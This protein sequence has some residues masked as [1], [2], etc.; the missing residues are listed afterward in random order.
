MWRD[1]KPTIP[2]LTPLRLIVRRRRTDYHAYYL[3]TKT[4]CGYCSC[5]IQDCICTTATGLEV[6]LP[7]ANGTDSEQAEPIQTASA[8]GGDV[9]QN[10]DPTAS[11]Q[12][13]TAWH[14]GTGFSGLNAPS[15]AMRSLGLSFRHLWM[16]ESNDAAR[17]FLRDNVRPADLATDVLPAPGLTDIYVAGPPCQPFSSAGLKRQWQH[18]R[19][20]LY[21]AAVSAIC[22]AKPRTAVIE[23]SAHVINMAGGAFVRVV[24]RILEET[25]FTVLMKILDVVAMGV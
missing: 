18:D 8:P 5:P 14:L 7:L 10:D 19:A 24:R 22:L 6:A 9:D 15:W 13:T 1:R 16:S 17:R 3:V 20:P 4:R 12:S 11:V 23:N 21:C 2:K 25:G